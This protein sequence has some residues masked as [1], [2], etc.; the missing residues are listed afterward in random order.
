MG[1]C[2]AIH[3][4]C[5]Q[6]R[7]GRHMLM[8]QGGKSANKSLPGTLRPVPSKETITWRAQRYLRCL[9][10]FED[11]QVQRRAKCLWRN[12]LST[13]TSSCVKL[14]SILHLPVQNAMTANNRERPLFCLQHTR[15]TC[16]AWQKN[17]TT[18]YLRHQH[19]SIYKQKGFLYF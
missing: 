5:M 15:L 7:K 14:G 6:G 8:N 4:H 10:P 11:T 13:R 12:T 2:T 19:G 18:K 3:L 1:N 16:Q 17:F 9:V